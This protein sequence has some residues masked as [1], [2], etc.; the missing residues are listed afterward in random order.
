[1][2]KLLWILLISWSVVDCYKKVK[3][4]KRLDVFDV[5]V[6]ITGITCGLS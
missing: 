3:E 2:K 6:I 1:M 4:S 5:I